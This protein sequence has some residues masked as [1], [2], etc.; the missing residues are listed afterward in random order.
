MVLATN[1]IIQS[2]IAEK[3]DEEPIRAGTRREL[4][5][6]VYNRIRKG[7]RAYLFRSYKCE[8]QMEFQ[9]HL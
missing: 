2:S 5:S 7:V 8:R 6:G 4:R 9:I 3:Q 1:T